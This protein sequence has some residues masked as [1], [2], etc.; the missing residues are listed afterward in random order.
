MT[1]IDFYNQTR[2][3]DPF[4]VYCVVLLHHESDHRVNFHDRGS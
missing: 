3:A 1:L 2:S 4:S